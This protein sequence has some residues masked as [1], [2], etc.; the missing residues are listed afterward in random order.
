MVIGAHPDDEVLGLGGTIAK[1]AREAGEQVYVLIVTD[2]SSTQYP[3]DEQKRLRKQRELEASCKILGVADFVHGDLPDMQLDRLGHVPLN[4]FIAGHVAKWAPDA[5]YTHFP[6]V[7]K[8]HV[9]VYESTLVAARP[10]PGSSVRRL[11]LYPT[12]SATEWDLPVLK[13]P[14]AASAFVDIEAHLETKIRAL[15]CYDT[16]LREFPHPRS[17]EAI[18]ALAQACGL[19]VGLRYAEEFM[20]VRQID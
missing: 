8:D 13:R 18:R 4:Q 7:N 9:C 5:I 19:K 11:V 3:N 2:G 16:E 1:L 15:A 14:F 10:R 20:V 6:D 12:P 17:S